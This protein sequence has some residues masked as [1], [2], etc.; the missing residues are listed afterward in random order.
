MS[1]TWNSSKHNSAASRAMSAATLRI[2]ASVFARRLPLDA[3][4]DFEHE[5]VEMDP[6]LARARHRGKEQIHQHRFAAP[7]RAV[8][9]EPDRRLGRRR[10]RRGRSGRA[11]R[12]AR[13][14]AGTPRGRGRGFAAFRSPA[15]APGRAVAAPF[16]AAPDR[17]LSA[18]ASGGSRVGSASVRAPVV[19]AMAEAE[20]SNQTRYCGR[21][22]A[23]S[24]SAGAVRSLIAKSER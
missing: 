3:V 8:Q 15:V 4:M 18:L 14:R 23:G 12:A 11:S 10:S 17:P 7:D 6:P 20:G 1:S 2:G 21:K 19:S 16:G 13:S 9:V 5:G 22:G 24:T